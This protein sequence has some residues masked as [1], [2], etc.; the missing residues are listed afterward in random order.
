[1]RAKPEELE[2]GNF[3]ILRRDSGELW[4]LGRGG[5]G[6]T[7]KAEH[8]HLQRDCALKV[9]N[10]SRVASEDARRRFLQEARA[11]ASLQHPHIAAVYD[12]GEADGTFYYAMEYCAG[13]DLEKFVEQRGALSW[14]EVEPLA[15]QIAS[16]LSCAHGSGLLHRDLKPSNVMLSA[17]NEANF[18]LKLIDF[19]LVKVL[20]REKTSS[21]HVMLTQEGAAGFNPLTA[22]PEQLRDE[23]LDERSD[24]FSFGVTLLYLLCGGV[25]FGNVSAP[26][27]MA[28]RLDEESYENLLPADLTGAG[29]EVV[30]RLLQKKREQRY[31]SADE[32]LAAIQT[33]THTKSPSESAI[34]DG[35]TEEVDSS[36]IVEASQEV[37]WASAW[38][39]KQIQ[40]QCHSGA[41]Y[42]CVGRQQGIPDVVMFMPS[43]DSPQG[44]IILSHADKLVGADTCMLLSFVDAGYMDGERSYLCQPVM[45]GGGR[46]LQLL[47]A[48]GTFNLQTHLPLFQQMSKAIDEA[49][50]L[51]LPGLELNA[52]M[53]V[54]QD[55]GMPNDRL[56]ATADDWLAY[57]KQQISSDSSFVKSVSLSLLPKLEDPTDEDDIQATVTLEDLATDPITKFGSLIYRSLSG[58]SVRPAA[59]LRES[60]YVSTS[61]LSEESNRFLAE[62]IASR[63]EVSSAIE[64]VTMLCD[65]E[66]VSWDVEAL[67]SHLTTRRD[68]SKNFTTSVS[69]VQHLLSDALE[70]EQRK[71]KEDEQRQRREA[72][73]REEKVREDAAAAELKRKEQEEAQ[74]REQQAKLAAEAEQLK[75]EEL[76]RKK[77]EAKLTVEAEKLEI[78]ETAQKLDEDEKRK[79]E[80][81]AKA[82]TKKIEQAEKERLKLQGGKRKA[83]DE[84]RSLADAKKETDQLHKEALLAQKN[85]EKEKK[86]V[87]KERSQLTQQQQGESPGSGSKK[88]I[89]VIAAAALLIGILALIGISFSGNDDD[90]RNSGAKTA[91]T[92]RNDD[93]NPKNPEDQAT[94]EPIRTECVVIIP[95]SD[96]GKGIPDD[97]KMG[98]FSV[99]GESYGTLIK[100]SG[101]L[102][103]TITE[104]NPPKG[105]KLE[106][107]FN[108]KNYALE[109]KITFKSDHFKETETGVFTYKGAVLL[110][111]HAQFDFSPSL[112]S[113]FTQYRKPILELLKTRDHMKILDAEGS[114]IKGANV[115]YDDAS[116]KVNISMPTGWSFNGGNAKF[117]IHWPYFE[118]I[119]LEIASNGLVGSEPWK[120]KLRKYDLNLGLLKSRMPRFKTVGFIPTFGDG[121]GKELK[122]VIESLIENEEVTYLKSYLDIK[123]GNDVLA[124]PSQQGNLL[125]SGG[126]VHDE[127]VLVKGGVKRGQLAT[128]FLGFPKGLYVDALPIPFQY[129]NS[130][131][132]GGGY[133]YKTVPSMVAIHLQDSP[134]D[135]ARPFEFRVVI[136]EKLQMTQYLTTL[137]LKSWNQRTNQWTLT[138]VAGAQQALNLVLIVSQSPNGGLSVD[139]TDI[140]VNGDKKYKFDPLAKSRWGMTI[141]PKQGGMLHQ[142]LTMKLNHRSETGQSFVQNLDR[143]Y[144]LIKKD[145]DDLKASYEL[146]SDYPDLSPSIFRKLGE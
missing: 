119:N 41:Y 55:G 89:I 13:G 142:K 130:P 40:Q 110:N 84:K 141:E 49:A 29:R 135:V 129:F 2:F 94:G 123:G 23:D 75:V 67:E 98:L 85:A 121:I 116:G 70:A 131:A 18:Q 138:N 77:K 133:L 19:G 78:K 122:K 96:G 44:E 74:E 101:V 64:I 134:N 8:T 71:I 68:A 22:S 103:A 69:D 45:G 16:A 87:E 20:D 53:I 113:G 120:I 26:L 139:Y 104:A 34:Y 39:V 63:S 79:K 4:E 80:A 92:G 31:N 12:F 36:G 125:F 60:G 128:S 90:G 105:E 46:L 54:V 47:Q 62:I 107:R 37:D 72:Q 6:T 76:A 50:D 83:E 115:S 32:V 35:A 106:V 109:S 146:P 86:K 9:I 33:V 59:Y 88:K 24:L 48:Q 111:A 3:K 5:F 30:L 52:A 7:Y 43:S 126:V 42:R 112:S 118:P 100:D 17:G 82:E 95:L 114:N 132:K 117:Q 58:M 11:A 81:L 57:Y 127:G 38:E 136:E 73:E 27:M 108:N 51:G 143:D 56:S 14:A 1:M 102:K 28:Q 99:D 91:N 10:D 65:F 140:V 15:I 21:T 144:A 137:K 97:V 145:F 124:V 25:P 66:G 61:N 93:I